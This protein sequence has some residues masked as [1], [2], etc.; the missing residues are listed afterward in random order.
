MV[1]AVN[2]FRERAMMIASSA[3]TPFRRVLIPLGAALVA[4][5]ALARAPAQA[6]PRTFVLDQ[7]EGYGVTAC[8]VDGVACG[9]IVANAFCESQGLGPAVAWGSAADVTGAIGD[10]PGAKLP[11]TSV[12]IT[13]GD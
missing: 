4:L 10:K 12:I 3:A 7:H 13:C 5:A 8:L 9:K 11:A 1:T 6:E 2:E